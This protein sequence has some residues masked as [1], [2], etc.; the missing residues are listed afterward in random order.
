MLILS[1]V[2]GGEFVPKT[3]PWFSAKRKI[4]HNNSACKT[5]NNIEKENLRSGSGGKRLCWECIRLN[6]KGI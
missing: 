3:S 2:L 4:Y 5:G 1:H 6:D